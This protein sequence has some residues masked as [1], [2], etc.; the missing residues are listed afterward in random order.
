MLN[1][2]N[3]GFT[4]IELLITITIIAILGSIAVS[5]YRSYIVDARQAAAGQSLMKMANMMENCFA[6]NQTYA[7]CID[8][9]AEGAGILNSVS[10]GLANHYQVNAITANANQYTLSVSAINS[11][12][13]SVAQNCRVLGLD[14]I[15]RRVSGSAVGSLSMANATNDNCF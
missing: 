5:G 4:L 14:R 12:A 11:Q 15:G 10:S 1:K 6:L 9:A 13:Q 2:N 7:D 8:A 3:K